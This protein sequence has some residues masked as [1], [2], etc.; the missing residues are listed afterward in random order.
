MSADAIFL[1]LSYINWVVVSALAVGSHA[2]VLLLTYRSTPTRGYRGF[3]VFAA[4]GWAFLAWQI[5]RAHV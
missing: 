5:G 4:G 1:S 2:A 3:T